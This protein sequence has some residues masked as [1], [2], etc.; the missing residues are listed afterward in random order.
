RKGYDLLVAAL[1]RMR[2]LPWT[3]LIVGDC[4]RSPET[5]RQLEGDIARFDIAER[6]VLRGAAAS[7]EI[8]ALYDA[9]DVFVLPS[10]YEGYGMAYAEAVAH[11]LPVIGTTAGAVP[12][13]VP[14]SARI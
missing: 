1:A 3:L 4:S 13:T 12:G 14:E 8:A 10:R 5:V 9:A 7:D 6:I 11:G 2:D